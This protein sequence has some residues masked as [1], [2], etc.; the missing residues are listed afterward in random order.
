MSTTVW[1][2]LVQFRDY[3]Q[4]QVTYDEFLASNGIMYFKLN[5]SIVFA[6]NCEEFRSLI[7]LST[8]EFESDE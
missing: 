5:G 4:Q 7:C 1:T 8:E 2:S 6:I 3:E